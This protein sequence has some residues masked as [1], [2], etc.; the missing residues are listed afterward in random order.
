MLFQRALIIVICIGIMCGCANFN[1][2]HRELNVDEGKGALIDIKQ[3][4][5]IVSKRDGKTIV[6][7]EPSPD[8]LSSYAAEL[9]AEADLPEEI[10]ARLVSAFQEGSSFVGLRTQSIQLLRDSLYR[11]CEGHMSGAL[12]SA[13][14]DILM[15]RYQKYMVALLAIEQLTGSLRSPAVAINTEGSATASRSISEMRKEIESINSSIAELEKA[16]SAVDVTVDEKTKLDYEIKELNDDKK[17]IE[18][19]LK[20]V[21]GIAS[22]GSVNVTISS[23]GTP[24]QKDSNHIIAISNVVNDIVLGIIQTDDAGQLCFSYLREADNNK[25]PKLTEACLRLIQNINDSNAL[26]IRQAKIM[27][28][29]AEKKGQLTDKES[30]SLKKLLDN[31]GGAIIQNK[32]FDSHHLFFKRENS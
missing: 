5:V 27:L 4:A 12:D 26:K 22:K 24:L 7:A 9:A 2:I 17:A 15:R 11:L 25:N 23:V 6:C 14:Y 3:R 31:V 1:S 8:S 16:K 32:V 18:E 13:Q 19:G 21:R 20:A 10:T 30:D 29:N 28:D